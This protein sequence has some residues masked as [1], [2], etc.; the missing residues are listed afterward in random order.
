MHHK[1]RIHPSSYDILHP[2]SQPT[3]RSTGAASLHPSPCTT[4]GQDTFHHTIVGPTICPSIPLPGP[5]TSNPLQKLHLANTLDALHHASATEQANRRQKRE[6]S[7]SSGAALLSPQP[8]CNISRQSVLRRPTHKPYAT[9]SFTFHHPSNPY[10]PTPQGLGSSATGGSGGSSGV[11]TSF[12][13]IRGRQAPNVRF[14]FS[15]ILLSLLLLLE[16]LS[17]SPQSILGRQM[18]T[19]GDLP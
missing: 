7:T 4:V 10:A 15:A 2:N 3:K 6:A 8:R 17:D 1:C 18:F 14:L 12:A 5:H 13:T 19:G 9:Q 11:N 16:S